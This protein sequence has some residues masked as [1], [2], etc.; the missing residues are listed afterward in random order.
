ME[1]FWKG[2]RVFLTGGSGFIGSHLLHKLLDLGATVFATQHVHPVE[3]GA[4]ALHGFNTADAWQ[5]MDVPQE[6]FDI[7][8][9]LAATAI[10][11]DAEKYPDETFGTN[12]VGTYNVLRSFPNSTIIVASTDKVYGRSK[13]PY[14]EDTPLAGTHQIYEATKVAADVMAQAFFHRGKK[15]AITR[16]CNIFGYDEESTRIIP[17]IIKSIRKNG[18]VHIRTNPDYVRDYLY[19]QDIVDGYLKLGEWRH[20]SDWESWNPVAFNFGGHNLSVMDLMNKISEVMEYSI[21]YV[22]DGNSTGE[23]KAQSLDWRLAWDTLGWQ[24]SSFDTGI[25]KTINE[26]LS[27]EVKWT[28]EE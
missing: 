3:R 27:R 13:I 25:R 12:V 18:V 21:E 11:L 26:Y 24:P 20:W 2:K 28:S 19:V 7:V 17:H 9:H 22:V 8:F 15:V 6:A 1:S 5:F 4:I 23:I 16:A 10:V 14:T